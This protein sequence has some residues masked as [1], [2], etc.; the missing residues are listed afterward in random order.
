MLGRTFSPN[1]DTTDA[2]NGFS[3]RTCGYYFEW[4]DVH[5]CLEANKKFVCGGKDELRSTKNVQIIFNLKWVPVAGKGR[6]DRSGVRYCSG[7]SGWSRRADVAGPLTYALGPF[8]SAPDGKGMD[9]LK[10]FPDRYIRIQSN[11]WNKGYVDPKGTDYYRFAPREVEKFAEELAR[12]VFDDAW[13]CPTPLKL[14]HFH[15][16][17]H[18][19]AGTGIRIEPA[20]ELVATMKDEKGN[21]IAGRTVFFYA[22]DE[23]NPGQLEPGMNLL[24]VEADHRLG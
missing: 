15:P 17:E 8:D 16:F 19:K 3:R 1:W 22:V 11:A 10:Y 5:K 13:A 24:Q 4:E 14:R 2:G 18:F 9:Y 21:P 6:F 23:E 7:D 20:G 12:Q